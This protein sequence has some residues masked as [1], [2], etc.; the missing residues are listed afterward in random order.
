MSNLIQE[1]IKE[2]INENSTIAIHTISGKN[3]VDDAASILL[4]GLEQ[5]HRTLG[6]LPGNYYQ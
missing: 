5:S 4:K 1:Q 6:G 3:A 2:V